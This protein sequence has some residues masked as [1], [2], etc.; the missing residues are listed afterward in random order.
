M[1]VAVR[2]LRVVKM[3]FMIFL[4]V[5]FADPLIYAMSILPLQFFSLLLFW[6]KFTFCWVLAEHHLMAGSLCGVV[7]SIDLLVS[8]LFSSPYTYVG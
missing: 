8:S 6:H 1:S 4:P 5:F 7:S 3:C 2:I